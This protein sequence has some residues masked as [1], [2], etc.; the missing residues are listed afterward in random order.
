MKPSKV[1]LPVH[2][3][4]GGFGTHPYSYGACSKGGWAFEHLTKTFKEKVGEKRQEYGFP[5]IPLRKLCFLQAME[6]S[7]GAPAQV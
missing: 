1:T 4:G 5:F 2:S 3:L 6:E 7:S